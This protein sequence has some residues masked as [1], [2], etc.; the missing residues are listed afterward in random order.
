MDFAIERMALN[1]RKKTLV[2]SR[3]SLPLKNNNMALSFFVFNGKLVPVCTY[4]LL[5]SKL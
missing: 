5:K 1:F 2:H 4:I 3:L